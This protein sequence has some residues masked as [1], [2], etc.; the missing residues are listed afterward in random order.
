MY[1]VVDDG[2]CGKVQ[3]LFSWYG[4]FAEDRVSEGILELYYCFS[5][6]YIQPC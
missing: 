1:K 6:I 5:P 2:R 3:L 4:D